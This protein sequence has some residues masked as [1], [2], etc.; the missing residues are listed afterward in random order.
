MV[1]INKVSFSYRIQENALNNISLEIQTGECLLLCGESGCG[2]TTVTKLVNGLIPHFTPGDKLTGCTSVDGDI[3][4]DVKMYELAKKVGSVFQN[5]KSQFF[6]LDS[7]S[8]LA[9]GLENEG[10]AASEIANRIRHTVQGLH[11]E[12]LEHRNVYS[13]SGGEKQSLAF[14]SV[15]AMQPKVFVLDEPSANLDFK[16]VEAL[17]QQI[18]RVKQDGHTIIIAEHRLYFLAD[19]VDR[20]IYLKDGKIT[21]SW[22]NNEF[23]TLS[24]AKRTSLGLRSIRKI[25]PEI[26]NCNKSEVNSNLVIEDIS[27]A[28]R[29]KEILSGVNFSASNGDVIGIAGHNGVGKSTLC[30]CICGLL[31]T[32][33]GKI[34]LDGKILSLKERRKLCALVMQ[35]VNHQLFADS[36]WD[37]CELAGQNKTPAE[38]EHILKRFSLLKY[39]ECHPMALSGGQ[40]QRLAIVAAI[41]SEK[42]ILIFDE[43]TSGLDYKHMMKVSALFKELGE[44]GHIILVV[45]HDNEFINETCNYIYQL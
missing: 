41:L 34:Y 3:V 40:K 29:N 17:R 11:I 16:A 24:E 5:P 30:H 23:I 33:R 4:T 19:I 39:R 7:D 14:A 42:K 2:K 32:K 27:F 28:Y 15:H 25:K 38:I 12:H 21:E 36:V 10:V 37:E 31:K 26:P 1:K 22:N 18:I 45:S 35:D 20:V 13:M 43:P 8:E 6:Y 9:F 44:A